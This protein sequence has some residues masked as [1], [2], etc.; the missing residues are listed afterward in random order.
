MKTSW[1]TTNALYSDA[2]YSITTGVC[3]T[4]P[5]TMNVPEVHK[6]ELIKKTFQL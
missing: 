4:E 3:W 2:R 1:K 5:G 6:T